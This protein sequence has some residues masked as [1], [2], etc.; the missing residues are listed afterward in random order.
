MYF[1]FQQS[2]KILNDDFLGL[3]DRTYPIQNLPSEVLVEG[4]SDWA[5]GA[6]AKSTQCSVMLFG[7]HCLEVLTSNQTTIAIAS[8]IAELLALNRA[9]ASAI[10]VEQVL[11]ECNA[12][13][14]AVVGTDSNAARVAS[15]ASSRARVRGP[16]A[17]RQRRAR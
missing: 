17:K 16:R 3:K 7:S 14:R 11:R 12:P 5:G 15:P 10:L 2:P 8:A 4:D 6:D 1:F 13:V 9:G